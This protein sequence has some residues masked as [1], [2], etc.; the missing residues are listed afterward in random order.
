MLGRKLHLGLEVNVG[1]RSVLPTPLRSQV[2]PCDR[3]ALL[4]AEM[5]GRGGEVHI[6]GTEGP[7][8]F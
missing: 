5:T 8:L 3:E 6:R 2:S 4:G 7:S 1:M